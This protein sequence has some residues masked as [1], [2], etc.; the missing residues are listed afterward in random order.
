MKEK[1]PGKKDIIAAERSKKALDDKYLRRQAIKQIEASVK[2]LERSTA[3]LYDMAAAAKQKGLKDTLNQIIQ[4]IKTSELRKSQMETFLFQTKIMEEEQGTAGISGGFVNSIGVIM[5][6]FE[7]AL[8]EKSI[9]E[10]RKAMAAVNKKMAQQSKLIDKALSGSG[11]EGGMADY[12]SE[13]ALESEIEGRI[14]SIIDRKVQEASGETDKRI[15]DDIADLRKM[16][17][18]IDS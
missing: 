17:K 15:D 9:E 16:L 6:S 14:E 3:K 8:D 4:K 12:E 10:S 11:S 13:L 18:K 7:G 1:K 2:E 5:K